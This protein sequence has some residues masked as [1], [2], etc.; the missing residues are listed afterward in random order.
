[1]TSYHGKYRG[2]VAN[3]I[4]PLGLGRVQV[5]VPQVLGDGRL[6]W[7]MPCVPY[8]GPDV[9]FF[10]IPPNDAAIWVEFEGGDAEHPI[11][12]GAFWEEA[13]DVPVS[14]AI[15]QTKVLKTDTI[16]VTLDDLPGVGGVT[17]E[18]N[19]MKIVMTTT[20]IEIDNG[21]GAS[22]KLQ[23]PKVSINGSALEIT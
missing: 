23:G 14:P 11:W 12:V 22:V 21:T 18:T 13:G 16:T 5:E 4:D 3:N 10:F 7:A 6:T 15:P 9:G 17:I 19:G 1:M 8:A 2:K 20:G